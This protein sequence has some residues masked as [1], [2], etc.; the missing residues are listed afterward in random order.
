MVHPPTLGGVLDTWEDLEIGGEGGPRQAERGYLEP[1][2]LLEP[3]AS[4]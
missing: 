3:P 2:G 4:A 1:F